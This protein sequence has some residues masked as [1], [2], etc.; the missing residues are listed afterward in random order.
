AVGTGDRLV[1]RDEP[2]RRVAEDHRLLGAPGMR[3]LVLEPAARDQHAGVGQRLDDSVVGVALLALLGEHAL[4][5]KT[6]RRLGEGAVLVD[7]VGNRRVDAA[8]GELCGI[9]S[10]NIEVLA[11]VAGRG[12]DESG[13]GVVADMIAGKNGNEK[14]VTHR[15]QGMDAP[16]AGNR[17]YVAESLEFGY[18]GMLEG[19]R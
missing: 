9:R 5:R 17:I 12:V 18:A 3:I 2:L 16:S 4:S 14:I 13:A 6:R 11:A 7:G 1:H 15:L 10:P 8:R 19:V